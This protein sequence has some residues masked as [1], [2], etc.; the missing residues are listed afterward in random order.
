M[1][2]PDYIKDKR[3]FLTFYLC[4]MV[5]ISLVVFFGIEQEKGLSLMLY[6]SCWWGI[7]TFN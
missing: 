1:S 3:Y 2:L 5:F 7:S 4:M 6:I